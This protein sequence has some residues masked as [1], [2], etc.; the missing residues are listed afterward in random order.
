VLVALVL[1]SAAAVVGSAVASSASIP[2][3][4]MATAERVGVG[5]NFFRPRS[6][7]VRKN[8]R[9][10]WAWTGRRKHDV[11]FV[12]GLRSGRPRRCYARRTGTCTRP[13]RRRGTYGYVCVFHGTMTGR[14]R[15]G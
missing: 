1:I 2:P 11:R 14:V 6:V 7:R 10:V 3:T 12:S 5:D 15:V 13:F 4:A 9:V 8:A